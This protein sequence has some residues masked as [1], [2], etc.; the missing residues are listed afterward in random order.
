MPY[1]APGEREALKLLPPLSRTTA[2][3]KI[4]TYLEF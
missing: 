1:G 2:N 3:E 4:T